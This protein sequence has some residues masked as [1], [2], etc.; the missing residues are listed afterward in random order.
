MA[1]TRTPLTGF[2]SGRSC[3]PFAIRVKLRCRTVLQAFEQV[4]YQRDE[5]KLCHTKSLTS[6]TEKENLTS[7]ALHEI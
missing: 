6:R 5:R 7:L 2:E 1:R 4:R 3:D